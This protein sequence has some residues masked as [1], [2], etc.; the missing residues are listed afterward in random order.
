MPGYNG[1]VQIKNS[2]KTNFSGFL[3]KCD[4]LE[5]KTARFYNTKYILK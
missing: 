3:I 5:W 1:G 2:E 4:Q